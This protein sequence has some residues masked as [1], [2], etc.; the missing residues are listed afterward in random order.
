MKAWNILWCLACTLSAGAQTVIE[1]PTAKG[2]AAFA[3]VVDNQTYKAA[4]PSIMRYR[5]AVQR[6][7]LATYI[8]RGDWRLPHEAKADIEQVYRQAGTLEGIVLV[9]DIPVA[10]VRNAQH[11]TT[12]FKMNEEK[13]P[14]R[15]SSVPSDRYYDDLHLKFDFIAQDSV[16]P[17]LS[18]YRLRED[19]PQ[20]LRPTFYSARIACPA[21][22]EG[23]RH[24]RIAA[25]LDKC[26]Q[27]KQEG[28]G[29]VDRV[30]SFNGGSYNSDCLVAWMD[31]EKA[32]RENFPLAFARSTGF[33]HWNFRTE[34][35]MKYPLLSEL[36]R[37]DT[38]IFMFHEHGLPTKQLINNDPE[39]DSFGARLALFKR[40]LYQDVRDATEQ[41]AGE[42]SL[43]SALQREYGLTPAFWQELHDASYWREDSARQADLYIN[44]EDLRDAETNA[45]F[46]MFD[47]CY[48]GSFQDDDYLAAYY[49]F[50]PGRTVAAQGNTR[51]VLQDRWT[52][53]LLGLMSHGVRVGQYNR[54]VATLEGHLLGDPT[55]HFEPLA[56][57]CTLRDDLTLRRKDE[58]HWTRLLS[59]P[60]AD[61]QAVAWRMLADIQGGDDGALRA[62]MLE[63]FKSTPLNTVRAELLKL[64]ARK[65][66]ALFA[67]AVRRGIDAPYELVARH[68]ANYAGERGDTAVL[69]AYVRACVEDTER[70]R[71][72]YLLSTGLTLFPEA[73]VMAA[74]GRYYDSTTRQD[75]EAERKA[76]VRSV[77]AQFARVGRTNQRI[78]DPSLPVA[79]RVNAIRLLRNNPYHP[80]VALYLRT[81]QDES[82][83]LPVRVALAEALGWFTH[84]VRRADI[85]AAAK[86]MLEQEQPD[87]LRA[88]LEQTLRRLG[89]L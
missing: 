26:A 77:K 79:T 10:M 88:E 13:F 36:R 66:D 45:S 4:R 14:P 72:N 51:N 3:I 6:D 65:D 85:V 64:L 38:D 53:E 33:K 20:E 29:R 52:I 87:P 60:Y 54:L 82:S 5:D 57:G 42:D 9:G 43:R 39:G 46:V 15:E 78:A 89:A 50:N 27:R 73:D 34:E 19:S 80:H 47:A 74:L 59:S 11:L 62:R 32:Y 17:R 24:A 69:R 70:Q 49:L 81:L 55:A 2:A 83:P 25:F 22:W 7:G 84:S 37:E 67:E 35:R 63:A 30:V 21:G 12:A 76:V 75:A 16:T 48:N 1:Q 44:P 86:D 23:D 8:V 71:V 41:G 28:M 68:S 56:E 18:Y 31:E 61:V 40:A 58:A